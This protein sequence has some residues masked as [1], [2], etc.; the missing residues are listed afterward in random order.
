MRWRWN[1]KVWLS[2]EITLIMC[3]NICIDY[4]PYPQRQPT[5]TNL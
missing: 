1:V 3:Y 2:V 5:D 4:K